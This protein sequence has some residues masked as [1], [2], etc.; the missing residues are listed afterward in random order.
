M[1]R[2][3]IESWYARMPRLERAQALVTLDSVAYTPDQVLAEVL[4]GTPTGARLQAMIE[5]RSFTTAEDKYALAIARLKERLARMA[6]GT[7][8]T[9]GTRT[10]TPAELRREI[11]QGTRVGRMFIEAEVKRV[12]EVLAR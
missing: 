5:G 8:V 10:L 2:E 1:S 6:P 11:D 4:G 7:K 3:F 9:V 12:E